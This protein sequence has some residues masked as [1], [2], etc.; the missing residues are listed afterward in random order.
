MS[1]IK[2]SAHNL[3]EKAK[4]TNLH[5]AVCIAFDLSNSNIFLSLKEKKMNANILRIPW[6]RQLLN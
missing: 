6:A 1:L 4:C 5:L 2:T 3:G